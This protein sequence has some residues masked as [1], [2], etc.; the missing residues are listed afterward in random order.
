V[1]ARIANLGNTFAV[2]FTDK[3]T[4]IGGASTLKLWSS[5]AGK[6]AADTDIVAWTTESAAGA[7]YATLTNR[8][9]VPAMAL[10]ATRWQLFGEGS[11]GGKRAIVVQTVV[12]PASPP[13]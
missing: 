13:Q 5:A 4:T 7:Q 1:G 9:L 12:A 8:G 2:T 11:E 6:P 10:S 3:V